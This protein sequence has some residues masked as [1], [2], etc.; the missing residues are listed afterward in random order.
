MAYTTISGIIV[1]S[2]WRCL[3]WIASYTTCK[4]SHSIRSKLFD[5][6]LYGSTGF[7]PDSLE[8]F[9]SPSSTEIALVLESKTKLFISVHF[10][11]RLFV[12]FSFTVPQ[13]EKRIYFLI[14][15]YSKTKSLGMRWWLSGK[16]SF[17]LL[18]HVW[19]AFVLCR[20][21]FSLFLFQAVIYWM[22]NPLFNY[23]SQEQSTS[24]LFLLDVLIPLNS[25]R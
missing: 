10:V 9:P 12:S 17:I 1:S 23:I 7:L 8:T 16:N 11:F 2:N 4:L 14:K 15:F 13:N 3:I 20:G 22:R 21:Q 5:C 18:S 6:T 25:E 24:E 19:I